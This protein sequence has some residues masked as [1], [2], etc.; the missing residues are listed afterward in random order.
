MFGGTA[1]DARR[2]NT[3]AVDKD[4]CARCSK[5]VYF[6]EKTIG[7]GYA[8]DLA[9][10]CTQSLSGCRANQSLFLSRVS[11]VES[12]NS[13]LSNV[14]F[15]CAADYAIQHRSYSLAWDWLN[16]YSLHFAGHS[17]VRGGHT[18][19]KTLTRS[20]CVCTGGRGTRHV[21][22]A[23]AAIRTSTALPQRRTAP[24]TAK[25]CGK[26]PLWA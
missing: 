17:V 8:L 5:R 14:A 13:R 23:Q 16:Q 24:C 4:M 25:V 15:V 18:L 6:A 7:A 26:A 1:Y 22:G 12:D 20:R 2:S 19:G 11:S 3:A 9:Q 21:S 10:R